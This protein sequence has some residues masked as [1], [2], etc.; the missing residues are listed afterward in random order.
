MGTS[1]AML[2]AARASLGVSGRP[3][4]I[5]RDYAARHGSDFLRAPWCDMAI[6]YWA[7]K[8]GNAAAVLPGGD[9]AYTV[10]HAED[11]RKV[12]RWHAGTT[13]NIDRSRPGD[14]AFF[15]WGTSNSIEDIDHTGVIEKVLGGGRVQTIEGNTGDACRRRVRSA[16]VIAGYGRPAYSDAPAPPKAPPFR[17]TLKQPPLMQGDDVRTW[18]AQM[19]RR[20]W[21]IDVDG[22]YG[23]DSERVCRAFQS[24]KHL[25]VTGDVDQATWKATWEAPIT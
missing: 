11:F 10:W 16:S 19:R 22:W 15:D 2:A 17:R 12:G 3:N 20:G 24:D 23:P 21:S 8:S 13:A 1:T 5:T 4:V 6:T 9:R 14:I 18:Q 7:R 25:R